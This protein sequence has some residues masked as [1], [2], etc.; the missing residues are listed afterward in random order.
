MFTS[1]DH[2]SMTDNAIEI[3][4]HLTMRVSYLVD[5]AAHII[6][7]ENDVIVHAIDALS[8]VL[9]MKAVDAAFPA[10]ANQPVQWNCL[11]GVMAN[12]GATTTE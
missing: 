6:H 4:A 3:V 10:I 1:D 12:A 9:K 2:I 5:L 8:P 7:I 11:I